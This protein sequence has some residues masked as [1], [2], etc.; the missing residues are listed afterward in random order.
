MSLHKKQPKKSMP[1]NADK[2]HLWKQDIAASVDLFNKWFLKFA[3]R[4]YRDSRVK[5]TKAVEATLLQTKDL[6]RITAEVLRAHPEG[7]PTLRMC[8]CPPLARDRLVG[9]SEVSKHLVWAME[10]GAVP[11]RV[12]RELLGTELSKLAATLTK[13]LDVDIFPWLS[14]G[15]RPTRSVRLRASTII[16]D[17]LCGA[18]SDPIVRNAQE[19]RQLALIGDYLERKG[20]RKKQLTPGHKL[21]EMESGTYSYRTV[22]VVKTST[23]G[24]NIPIDIVIQPKFAR[25]GKLPTL[26]EAKSAGDFTN[27]NKRRKEEATKIHQLKRTYGDDVRFILFL[28]G[29]F[30]SGY[31]GYEAAEGI[32]WIWEHRIRDLDQLGI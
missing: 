11:T 1:I 31:L 2:P 4:A 22:V 26:I 25:A 23:G 13:L 19:K 27:T 10:K 7:L 21:K 28:C 5:T 6:T 14:T 20:Y 16:A 32:D 17:R 15:G 3:P 24:V 9:L 18:V 29:Y 8:G 12:K 30:D